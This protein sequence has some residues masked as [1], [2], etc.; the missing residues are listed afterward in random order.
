MLASPSMRVSAVLVDHLA[1]RGVDDDRVR[2]QQLQPPRRQQMEGRRR[3]RAIHRD[4][5]HA[6]QH[7][8]EALPVGRLEL[9]LEVRPAPRRRL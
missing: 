1:A 6:R 4:D 5:V 2:L 7:L 8:V 9:V 3:V